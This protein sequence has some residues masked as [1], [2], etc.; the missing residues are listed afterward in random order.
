MFVRTSNLERIIAFYK[1]MCCMTVWLDSQPGISMLQHGN[2]IVGFIETD[3][4]SADIDSLITFFFDNKETVDARFLT[5]KDVAT[6]E[7][8]ENTRYRIYNFFAKDPDGRRIE[9]QVFNHE[10]LPLVSA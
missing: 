6:S 3:D 9:F 7:P 4:G 5:L 2:M 1:E 8:K 10:L